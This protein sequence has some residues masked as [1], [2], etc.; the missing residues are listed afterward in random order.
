MM[1]GRIGLP[2]MAE[3]QEWH[4]EPA[5]SGLDYGLFA[6]LVVGAVPMS[7]PTCKPAARTAM[8]HA[9]SSNLSKHRPAVN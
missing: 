3:Q 6:V 8:R 2:L 1:A 7:W 9:A 5:R 4:K